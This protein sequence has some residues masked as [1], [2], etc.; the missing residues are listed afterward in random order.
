MESIS[1]AVPIQKIVDKLRSQRMRD[2]LSIQTTILKSVSDFMAEK[3]VVQLLPS[4]VSPVTDPLAHTVIDASIDYYGQKLQLTKSMIFHKQVALMSPYLDA[5]YIVSPNVRLEKEDLKDSDR[6]LIEFTQV[7]IEFRHGDQ[8]RFIPFCEELMVR[9]LS[10]VKRSHSIE[11]ARLGRTLRVPQRPFK[12]FSMSEIVPRFGR[13]SRQAEDTLSL[14]EQDMFWITD[15]VR[16]FYD[17]EEQGVHRNYDLIYPEGYGEAASGAEREHE[18]HKIE[19]KIRERGQSLEDY[20]F[21]SELVRQGKLSRTVGLGFGVER[22]VRYVCGVMDIGD[23][24]PFAKKP[25]AHSLL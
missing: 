15:H 8:E 3:K 6:H 17:R 19:K 14:Y 10:D 21:F 7:D 16:E 23:V 1:F 22:L 13:N 12:R 24:S 5:L 2:I 11:L 25:A 9:I 20:G 18:Q 4:V